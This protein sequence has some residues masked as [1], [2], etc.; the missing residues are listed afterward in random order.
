M[1]IFTKKPVERGESRQG[2]I[3]LPQKIWKVMKKGDMGK[4]VIL[5]DPDEE[6]DMEE[7]NKKIKDLRA[8]AAF[9]KEV[10]ELKKRMLG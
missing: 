2:I 6:F 10:E 5:L 3:C 4:I 7:Y 1:E 8:L 9:N